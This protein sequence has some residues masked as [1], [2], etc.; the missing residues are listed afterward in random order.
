VVNTPVQV[1]LETGDCSAAEVVTAVVFGDPAAT[2]EANDARSVCRADMMAI[3][4][5]A[6][7][8]VV[9]VIE[10]AVCDAT[11]SMAVNSAF[12]C[13]ALIVVP[14]ELL[15]P[16]TRPVRTVLIPFHLCG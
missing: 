1:A 10:V 14:A 8:V 5:P 9:E 12:H 3:V 7:F 2:A 13:D 11:V 16:L 6:D 15:P 4:S